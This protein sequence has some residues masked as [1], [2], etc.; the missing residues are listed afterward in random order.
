MIRRPPRSTLFPYTTLFRSHKLPR[1]P[2][3]E[4]VARAL[5]ADRFV[6]YADRWVDFGNGLV[7]A[8]VTAL[9]G[10]SLLAGGVLLAVMALSA[11]GPALGPPAAGRPA[12]AAPPAP[13]GLRPPPGWGA[14][15]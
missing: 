6:R 10:R 11:G 4:V 1:T 14:G 7:I 15:G 9:A 2:P 5:D 8:G 12:A 13:G 3:G